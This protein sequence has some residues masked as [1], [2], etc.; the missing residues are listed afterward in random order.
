M[1]TITDQYKIEEVS[2]IIGYLIS[3]AKSCAERIG[4]L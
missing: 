3:I 4:V 1:D 2:N